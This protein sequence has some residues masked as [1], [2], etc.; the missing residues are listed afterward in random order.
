MAATYPP[1][2]PEDCLYYVREKLTDSDI[3]LTCLMIKALTIEAHHEGFKDGA[4]RIRDLTLAHLSRG[5][6]T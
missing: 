3:E 4:E 6:P 2:T 5:R 1:R